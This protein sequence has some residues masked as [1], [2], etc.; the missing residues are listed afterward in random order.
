M[1]S[2]LIAALPRTGSFFLSHLLRATGVAGN[3]EEYGGAS[4]ASTWQD[5]AGCSS[6]REYFNTYMAASRTPNGVFGAKLMW[7]QFCAFVHDTRTYLEIPT[8]NRDAI[9]SSV[10]GSFIF[11]RLYRE[12]ELRQAISLVLAKRT[13][14]W[15]SVSKSSRLDCEEVTYSR[16]AIDSALHLIS[17]ENTAWKCHLQNTTTSVFSISYEQLASCPISVL[18]EILYRLGLSPP[19]V[20]EVPAMVRQST[21]VNE[22]WVERYLSGE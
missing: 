22:Q 5:F 19:K 11:I 6:H 15:S 14:R 21:A 1:D 16:T 12:D 20:I 13:G 9:A 4:D 10:I 18:N 8:T 17:A 7:S 2:Y 3:P